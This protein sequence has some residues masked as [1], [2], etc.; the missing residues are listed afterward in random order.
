[1]DDDEFSE[2]A[3]RAQVVGEFAESPG[4]ELTV[5]FLKYLGESEQKRMLQGRC[6]DWG[7][8]KYMAG[9]LAG[10][11]RAIHAPELLHAKMEAERARL[12]EQQ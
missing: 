8:Y 2:I 5:D 6:E 3:E 7:E 1:M 11:Q 9:V 4:W 12:A 10:I